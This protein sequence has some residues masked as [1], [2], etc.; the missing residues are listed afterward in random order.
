MK[1]SQITGTV[2]TWLRASGWLSSSLAAHGK[3]KQYFLRVIPTL[4]HYPDIVPDIPS[5]RIYSICIYIYMYILR[6]YLAFYLASSLTF[7]LASI[8]TYVLTFYLAVFL[9]LSLTYILTFCL[10]FDLAFCLAFYLACV[11]VQARSTAS[12]G[13]NRFGS[14]CAPLHPGLAEEDDEEEGEEEDLHLC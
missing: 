8:L 2:M 3:K 5:G 6:F 10:A 11:W 13:C 7:Y 9:A 12:C 4:T 14:R 1:P